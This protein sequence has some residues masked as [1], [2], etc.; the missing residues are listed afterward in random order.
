MLQANISK[1]KILLLHLYDRLLTILISNNHI[2]AMEAYPEEV[3]SKTIGTDSKQQKTG[4]C[5]TKPIG[6]IYIGKVDSI[7]SNIQSAFIRINL[8][9]LLFL[10]MKEASSAHLTNRKSDGT[11]KVGDEILVQYIKEPIKSKLGGAST[12]LS[13]TGTYVIVSQKKRSIAIQSV[14]Q[15]DKENSVK[16]TSILFSRKIPE[17]LK[18]RFSDSEVLQELSCRYDIMIRTNAGFL[19]DISDAVSEAENL[20]DRLAK[21]ERNAD[22]RTCFSCLYK[23]GPAYLSFLQNC[24]QSEYDEIVTDDRSLYEELTAQMAALHVT[25]PI[26]LYE[27]AML[28]LYKLYS[29][30]TRIEELT[31]KKVWLK[32][33]AY[34]VIEQTEALVSIDVNSGKCEHGKSPEETFL[35]LNLEA[36]AAIARELRARNLSGIILVD[37]INL[38]KKE[39]EKLLIEEMKHLLSLDSVPAKVVDMTGL[40]LMEIT[41]K[42]IKPPV[43]EQLGKYKYK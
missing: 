8:D 3:F 29:V 30:E 17:G 28:P 1:G 14:I 36:A 41:R 18:Y 13:L 10:P 38:H 40:G 5:I 35:R 20:A 7:A 39:N 43:A 34:L 37:F 19:D 33:G 21:I 11:L 4:Q 32:S 12:V 42:K 25:A 27:D 2:L 22:S 26:R 31:G 15:H 23:N 24:Y 6:N 9:E 16:Q